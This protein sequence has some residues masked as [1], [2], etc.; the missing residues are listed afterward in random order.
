MKSFQ[1]LFYFLGYKQWN[2]CKI[3]LKKEGEI[4]TRCF[5]YIVTHSQTD[6]QI[7]VGHLAFIS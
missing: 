6:R 5:T 2:K 1:S 7:S 3:F 4:N